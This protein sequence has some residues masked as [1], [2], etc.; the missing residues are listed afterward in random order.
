MNDTPCLDKLTR[1]ELLILLKDIYVKARAHEALALDETFS[2]TIVD[3]VAEATGTES[4][5]HINN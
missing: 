3:M 2:A 4:P 1:K 5:A